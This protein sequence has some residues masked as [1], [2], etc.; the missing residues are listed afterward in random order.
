MGTQPRQIIL[1]AISMSAF[2]GSRRYGDQVRE[3]PGA[4][5]ALSSSI[6]RVA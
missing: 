2:T 1:L 4:T 5:P 3:F 6:S